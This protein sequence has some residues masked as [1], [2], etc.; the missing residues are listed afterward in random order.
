MCCHQDK[1]YSLQWV[2]FFHLLP[3]F[4]AQIHPRSGLALKHGITCLNTPETIDSAYCSKVK[5]LLINCGEESFTIERGMRIAQTV[6]APVIQGDVCAFEPDEK[7]M[8]TAMRKIGEAK[9]QKN[10]AAMRKTA[11]VNGQVPYITGEEKGVPL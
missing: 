3:G 4:K 10:F 9:D 6:I 5:V 11:R 2:L 7:R 8:S 1:A